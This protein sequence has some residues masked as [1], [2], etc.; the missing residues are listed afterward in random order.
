[1]SPHWQG[2]YT[3]PVQIAFETSINHQQVNKSNTVIHLSY[4]FKNPHW[5]QC[6]VSNNGF[7]SFWFGMVLVVHG[8]INC[9]ALE[10]FV[11]SF[12]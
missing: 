11:V 9:L 4:N 7:G 10:S 6:P 12:S 2:P 1:M 3:T 5:I 8:F